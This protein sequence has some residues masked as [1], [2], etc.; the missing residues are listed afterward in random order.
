MPTV[1]QAASVANS[2]VGCKTEADTQK[3]VEFVAKNDSI[4]L[5][6]FKTP[7]IKTGDCSFLST[8]MPITIDKKDGQF[9]C[10][11]PIGDLDCFWA[12]SVAINQIRRNP[13]KLPLL[14]LG[15]QDGVPAAIPRSEEY[16]KLVISIEEAGSMQNI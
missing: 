9:L 1:A 5:E 15:A 7:K 2:I 11:R 12:A 8:G 14:D 13:R 3:V 4:R 16:Q 10:V 6:K